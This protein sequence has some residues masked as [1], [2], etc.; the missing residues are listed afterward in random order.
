[1][2]AQ[3]FNKLKDYF[4]GSKTKDVSGRLAALKKLK[5]VLIAQEAAIF[6]SAAHDNKRP[7]IEVFGAELALLH[8]EIDE[9]CAQ[10]HTWAAPRKVATE[11]CGLLGSNY[12]YQE[13]YGVVLIIA[14]W[15]FP[16][17][18]TLLPLV[19]AVAAGNCVLIKPSEFAPA[20][21][22][23]IESIIRE[24]F[25]PAY[26]TVVQGD[27]HTAQ[28][29]LSQPFDYIFFTGSSKVGS[30]VYQEAAKRLIPVTLE[31]GGKNPTIITAD[32]DISY[33]AQ[34]I[35]WGKFF[36]AGQSCVAPDYVLI[37]E[38]RYDQFVDALKQQ[39][40][41]MY[42]QDS[43]TS[44]DYA[45]IINEAHVRRLQKLLSGGTVAFG[46]QVD[47]ATCFVAPTVLT[48]VRLDSACM[49]EEIFGPLLPII[50]YKTL[51]EA[52]AL[53]RKYPKPLALYV[54]SSR[55]DI[56]EKLIQAIPAGGGCINDVLLHHNAHALPFGGV[57]QSGIGAYH[58]KYGFETFSHKKAIFTSSRLLGR[59]TQPPY[60]KRLL[61]LLQ[62]WYR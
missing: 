17:L 10:L 20:Q 34:R 23:V 11:F 1:M 40:I 41:A 47:E 54:F 36:N 30:L 16:F 50:P 59:F 7:A 14:P 42:G 19:H 55:S 61:K 27:A 45:R 60:K 51:D 58:G 24:S 22:A 29:L 26:V 21:A 31:L 2:I 56:Q 12:I 15:N 18:L 44:P 37:D 25:D 4:L 62:W 33:A 6:Q 38:T 48:D 53:V 57:G 9:T 43:R 49:R 32:A 39:I 52:C 13:P 46:G 3:R 5:Q 35:A 8:T 28:Q